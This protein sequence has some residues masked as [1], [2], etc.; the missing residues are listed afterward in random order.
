MNLI[1]YWFREFYSFIQRGRRGWADSDTWGFDTYLARIIRDSVRHLAK[2]LHGCPSEYYD[3]KRIND[4]CWKYKEMLE[5]IASGFDSYMDDIEFN[6]RRRLVKGKIIVKIDKG[7][8]KIRRQKVDRA[9]DL[10]KKHFPGLW[11]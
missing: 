8:E 1:R 3:S 11:D 7:Q 6:L 5:E 4:E 10:L 9:F 2:D